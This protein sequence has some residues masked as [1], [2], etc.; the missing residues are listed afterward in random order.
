MA[1]CCLPFCKSDSK[2]DKKISFHEFPLDN[3]LRSAWL[4]AVSH[5]NF[6]PNEASNSS[7]VCSKHFKD[8]DYV[9]HLKRRRLKPK[10]VPSL[11]PG[12]PS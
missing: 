4:K 6:H 8:E 10:S 5:K 11:F 3:N 12:Y 9:P 7:R 1:N 2:R